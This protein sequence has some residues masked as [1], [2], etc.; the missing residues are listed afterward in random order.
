MQGSVE[1]I[2]DSF[3]RGSLSVCKASLQV[4]RALVYRTFSRVVDLSWL[5]I[6]LLY[7]SSFECLCA[8]Q[9]SVTGEGKS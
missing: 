1:C 2:L 3:V 9:V 6:G 8:N 4:Y 5:Y 7:V